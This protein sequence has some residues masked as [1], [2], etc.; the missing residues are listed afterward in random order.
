MT[1]HL[2]GAIPQG[3][4]DSGAGPAYRFTRNGTTVDVVWGNGHAILPT[5]ASMAQAYDLAGNKIPT[6]ITNGQIGMDLNDAPVFVEHTGDAITPVVPTTPTPSP[7]P[8][9]LPTVASCR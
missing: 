3:R 5:S 7:L 4:F 2:T 9:P 6:T 1:L 8:S